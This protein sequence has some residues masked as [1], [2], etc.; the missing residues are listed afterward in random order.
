LNIRCEIYLDRFLSTYELLV[1]LAILVSLEA[2]LLKLLLGVDGRKV[3]IMKGRQR[4]D[5]TALGCGMLVFSFKNG[6]S[7]A[8]FLGFA[9]ELVQCIS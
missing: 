6:D 1:S 9:D 7:C 5:D 4:L 8:N 2:V 3:H